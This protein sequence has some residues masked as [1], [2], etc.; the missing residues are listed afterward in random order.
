MFSIKYIADRVK[1]FI[2]VP[3]VCNH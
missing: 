2:Y 3:C 1:F